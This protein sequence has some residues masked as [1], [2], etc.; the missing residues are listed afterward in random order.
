MFHSN[1]IS[2]SNKSFQDEVASSD[3]EGRECLASPHS[4]L[5]GCQPCCWTREE[6]PSSLLRPEVSNWDTVGVCV[7]TG[8]S[9]QREGELRH[10]QDSDSIVEDFRRTNLTVGISEIFEYVEIQNL[11]FYGCT[12][13]GLDFWISQEEENEGFAFTDSS[14][15][16]QWFWTLEN[17]NKCL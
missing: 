1:L 2:L 3:P 5:F 14:Q 6:V 7:H 10:L 12:K 9:V 4:S 15:R 11:L 17:V 13:R 16:I 8:D